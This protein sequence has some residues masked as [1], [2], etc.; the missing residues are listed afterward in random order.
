[1]ESIHTS[2]REITRISIIERLFFMWLSC[3]STWGGVD[4]KVYLVD[5]GGGH[6][7]LLFFDRP[8]GR[9]IW[10]FITDFCKKLSENSSKSVAEILKKSKT[11]KKQVF[12]MHTAFLKKY[13]FG[14]KN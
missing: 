11:P 12:D 4:Q 10:R 8:P 14:N 6:K 3:H 9:K 5:K 2:T 1:M 7:S 13:I